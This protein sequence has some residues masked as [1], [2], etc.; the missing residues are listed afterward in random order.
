MKTTLCISVGA[1]SAHYNEPTFVPPV[2]SNVCITIGH[3]SYSGIVVSV[4]Y[5]YQH[6][7]V[8]HPGEIELFISVKAL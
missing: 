1:D 8:E 2:G 5:D 3:R 6:L 4:T 7:A